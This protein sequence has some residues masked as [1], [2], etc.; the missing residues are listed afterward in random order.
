MSCVRLEVM[1]GLSRAF[2]SEGP[3]PFVLEREID[4]GATVRDLLE[5]IAAQ[6]REVKEALFDARTGR[7]AGHI[8]AILNG[9]FLELA[10]GLDTKLKAGD[11][12]RL[13]FIPSGGQ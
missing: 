2:G 3:G 8:S 11:T 6:N 13:M 4:D 7:L 5:E 12:L 9:R 10:G 1:P